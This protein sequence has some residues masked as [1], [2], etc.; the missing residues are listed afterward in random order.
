MINLT[1]LECEV[2]SALN[3]VFNRFRADSGEA[4]PV[5]TW[6]IRLEMGNKLT[7]PK[8]RKTLKFL[9]DLGLVSGEKDGNNI[10]WTPIKEQS[11]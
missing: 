6:H 9:S 5:A 2:L 1:K 4:L 10:V 11:K 3:S 7:S 8:I